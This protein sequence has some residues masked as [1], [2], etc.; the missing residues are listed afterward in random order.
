MPLVCSGIRSRCTRHVSRNPIPSLRLAHSLVS[1]Q[2]VRR[3]ELV[4]SGSDEIVQIK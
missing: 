1:D 3:V 4:E 2:A